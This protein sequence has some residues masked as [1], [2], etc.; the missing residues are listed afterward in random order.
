MNVNFDLYT[1]K[2]PGGEELHALT[3]ELLLQTS[4]DPK[5]LTVV[6]VHG[7]LESKVEFFTHLITKGKICLLTHW[8]RLKFFLITIHF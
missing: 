4:F 3:P 1:Q 7:V 8:L 5:K 2:H 6:L